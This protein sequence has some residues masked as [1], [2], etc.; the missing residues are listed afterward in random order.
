MPGAA[1]LSG[2]ARITLANATLSM[3]FNVGVAATDDTDAKDGNSAS[4]TS[5]LTLTIA[6]LADRPTDLLFTGSALEPTAMNLTYT[7]RAANGNRGVRNCSLEPFPCLLLCYSHRHS[8]YP[9]SHK[10]TKAQCTYPHARIHPHSHPRSHPLPI[11][12]WVLSL[13]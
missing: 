7:A 13:P 2:S 5:L 4:A 3:V 9:Q 6:A 11:L 8:T 10:Y 1:I 12:A